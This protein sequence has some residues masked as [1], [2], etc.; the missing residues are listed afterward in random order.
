M[1]H[2]SFH[3]N[4][5][6]HHKLPLQPHVSP[7]FSM[8]TSMCWWE[9]SST[10]VHHS[11]RNIWIHFHALLC[12]SISYDRLFFFS[13]K[14]ISWSQLRENANFGNHFQFL[15]YDKETDNQHLSVWHLRLTFRLSKSSWQHLREVPS[16]CGP[17]LASSNDS[18]LLLLRQEFGPLLTINCYIKTSPKATTP[19]LLI[20]EPTKHPSRCR[21]QDIM[22][23]PVS[24]HQR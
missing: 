7:S 12:N 3:L 5:L 13:W 11:S 8:H 9:F 2:P 24:F 19:N 18:H 15:T 14:Q 21:G 16:S 10:C 23:G 4:W 17:I 22:Q 20:K 6:Y 1:E